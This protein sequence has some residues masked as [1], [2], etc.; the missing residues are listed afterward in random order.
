MKLFDRGKVFLLVVLVLT[1][2]IPIFI[3]KPYYLH[4]LTMCL[5]WAY[6]AC[7]WNIVGGFAGQLSLGHGMFTA[8]GAYVTVI[9][10]NTFGL[11]P[12]LGMFVGGGAAVILSLIIGFPT[13]SLRGAYFALATVALSEGMVVL[14]ENTEKIG[15]LLIGG[16]EGISLKMLGNAPL[17]FQFMGKAPYFYIALIMLIVVILASRWLMNSRLG[18][19]LIAL[20]EDED[21]AKALGI[22]VRNTKLI[23]I[24]MSAF[25]TALGGAFYA[26][27]IHYLQPSAIAGAAMSTQMVFLT[28]V[29][30]S[31]TIFGPVIGGI[32]LSLAS[33]II[34]F[35]LGDKIMG[36][37]LFIYGLIVVLVIVYKPRGIIEPLEKLYARLMGKQHKTEEVET[38][39]YKSA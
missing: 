27:M 22:N 7:A 18:Y 11:S 16:A 20:R 5:F 31:G 33:E 8:M 23:A 24:A 30:G 10:F 38:D 35:F 12:W 21:A 19:Y 37:H 14:L 39:A 13:F 3:T 26:Q 36:L 9:L 34:R 28:I 15:N 29:G 4:V 1:F 25:F 32:S 6:L 2:M 17:Q